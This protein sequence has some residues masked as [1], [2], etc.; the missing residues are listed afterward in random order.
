M[1]AVCL[2]IV[3]LPFWMFLI[4][5]TTTKTIPIIPSKTMKRICLFLCHFPSETSH[6]HPIP[7]FLGCLLSL[8]RD[9]GIQHLQGCRHLVFADLSIP[10]GILRC[11]KRDETNVFFC[12]LIMWKH[13][14]PWDDC[15]NF[16]H[17]E[18]Y[19]R[20]AGVSESSLHTI[21][22]RSYILTS[23]RY[24][25]NIYKSLFIDYNIISDLNPGRWQGSLATSWFGISSISRNVAPQL[26][27]TVSLSSW[28]HIA[29]SQALLQSFHI[30]NWVTRIYSN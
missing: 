29:A 12:G 21:L 23:Y 2:V 8:W 15:T 25:I 24:T 30:P 28:N 9:L 5:D 26:L 27:H 19:I 20:K 10:I 13:D 11:K 6:P 4:P 3:F 1:S 17:I 16:V 18:P 14:E 7:K 22:P